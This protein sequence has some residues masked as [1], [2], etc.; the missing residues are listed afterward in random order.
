MQQGQVIADGGP[1]E[2]RCNAQVRTA[3][4]GTEEAV[5]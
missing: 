2:I 5:C 3:Y 4:L 1:E